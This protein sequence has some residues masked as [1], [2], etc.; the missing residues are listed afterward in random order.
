[1]AALAANMQSGQQPMDVLVFRPSSPPARGVTG[2]GRE[3]RRPR[4]TSSSGSSR[5]LR[6]TWA[7]EGVHAEPH[8]AAAPGPSA[9]GDTR[10]T[11]IGA[12]VGRRLLAARARRG[13]QEGAAQPKRRVKKGRGDADGPMPLSIPTLAIPAGGLGQGTGK[14]CTQCSSASD[15]V[16]PNA[17]PFDETTRCA[18]PNRVHPPMHHGAGEP[19]SPSR[20]SRHPVPESHWRRE[21]LGHRRFGLHSRQWASLGGPRGRRLRAADAR[22]R[23]IAVSPYASPGGQYTRW[24]FAAV[25]HR[26]PSSSRS[27]AKQP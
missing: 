2:R 19:C 11:G 3:G 21:P 6:T 14:L 13:R 27:S 24:V 17:S 10:A 26:R 22:R 5:G 25:A 1:M 23:A 8:R 18:D 12:S 15:G 20:T 7:W 16:R 4:R 9:P